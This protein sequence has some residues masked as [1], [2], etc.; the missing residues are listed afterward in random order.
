MEGGASVGT[1]EEKVSSEGLEKEGRS[2]ISM[3][4]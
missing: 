3:V 1:G 4:G 2:A